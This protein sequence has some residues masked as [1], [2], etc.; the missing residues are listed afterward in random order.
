MAWEWV[1]LPTVG[2]AIGWIT[3]MIAIRLLFR[4][5]TPVRI[6][7]GLCFQG[8]LPRRQP[9]IARV[10]GETVERDLLPV[11]EIFEKLNIAAYERD[12][13]DAVSSY[14]DRRLGENLPATLPSQLR[15]LV[16]GYARRIVE[17]E[18]GHVVRD[19]TSR[20][21]ER[22]QGDV[23]IG[24]VVEEKLNQLDTDELERIVVRVAGTEL[25]AIEILGAVLGFIIG[26][27]QATLLTWL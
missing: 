16:A 15:K 10:V 25:R 12:V 14:V 27:L 26:L 8:V 17:R 4:P 6:G 18:A 22:V 21:R 23:K 3:N 1:I 9:D 2:A 7:R 24:Q 5:K 11:D 19:V 13:V 20:V